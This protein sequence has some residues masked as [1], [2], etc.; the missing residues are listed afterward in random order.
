MSVQA[1]GAKGG[2]A[3]LAKYGKEHFRMIGKQGQTIQSSRI[4]VQQRKIW[5]AMGG[6]PKRPRLSDTRWETEAKSN[7]RIGARPVTEPLSPDQIIS[8]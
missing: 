1:A 3:T 8:H 7:R 2:L 6:R 4:T 5:G